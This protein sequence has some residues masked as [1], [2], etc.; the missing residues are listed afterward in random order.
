MDEECK[1]DEKKPSSAGQLD[2]KAH[3]IFMVL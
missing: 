3:R 1:K 2:A